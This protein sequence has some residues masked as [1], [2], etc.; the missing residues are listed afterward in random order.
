MID[1][2]AN[3]IYANSYMANML[4]Y[5]KDEMNGKH[6]FFFMDEPAI[7]LA[8][9]Y[10]QRRA[11]GITENHTF[12]FTHKTGEKVFTTLNTYPL[13]DSNGK[14]NGSIAAITNI[15]ERKKLEEIAKQLEVKFKAVFDYASIGLAILTNE[16]QIID[17]NKKMCEKLQYSKAELLN[18]NLAEIVA[19]EYK[20]ELKGNI[21][22]LINGTS[23]AFVAE[24]KFIRKDSSIGWGITNFF[25][26]N[27]RTNSEVQI[28]FTL[29]D[30][31]KQKILE[32]EIF[33][34]EAL[35]KGVLENSSAAITIWDKEL[36]NIYANPSSI[37][38]SWSKR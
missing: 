32:D 26:V 5:T 23:S 8:K 6:L 4:G 33:K 14:Y 1:Q 3:T 25:I 28:I 2:N 18:L 21:D 12:E 11:E 7:E 31:T 22:N 17:A 24:Y 35:F 10:L 13:L 27:E 36:R 16:L 29:R 19:P 20:H 38:P 34:R 37:R 9:K 30:I 15:T